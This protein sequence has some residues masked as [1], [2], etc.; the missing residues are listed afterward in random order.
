MPI[1]SNKAPPAKA[2]FVIMLVARSTMGVA[3]ADLPPENALRI[4][5]A[6]DALYVNLAPPASKQ[7]RY[8]RS[9]ADMAIGEA[10][11]LIPDISKSKE[12]E[13]LLGKVKVDPLTT[14]RQSSSTISFDTMT[15]F[16]KQY[17]PDFDTKTPE[18]AFKSLSL[19]KMGENPFKS[20]MFPMWEHLVKKT[21]SETDVTK[22][23]FEAMDNALGD[24][25]SLAKFLG[26]AKTSTEFKGTVESLYKYQIDLWVRDDYTP[27]TVYDLLKL[28][29]VE[30]LNKL[31]DSPEF[32]MWAAFNTE[33]NSVY[34]ALLVLKGPER[35]FLDPDLMR[36]LAKIDETRDSFNFAQG[37]LYAQLQFLKRHPIEIESSF[38][39]FKLKALDSTNPK[40]TPTDVTMDPLGRLWVDYVYMRKQDENGLTDFGEVYMLLKNRIGHTAAIKT[41]KKVNTDGYFLKHLNKK[42]S[43]EKENFGLF[44][45]TFEPEKPM[46][47]SG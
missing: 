25:T 40:S 24:K 6:L 31:P 23:M 36:A 29:T 38:R 14:L 44:L 17:W 47:T 30:D 27:Q 15:K 2:L 21:T 45:K 18:E 20:P 12:I 8:L 13:S 26:Q 9:A 35:R 33:K 43:E 22:A 28:N 7:K 5:Q 3:T 34:E 42:S 46:E 11:R 16:Q 37:L 19:G 4:L 41:M 1:K 32:S 10:G 39:R